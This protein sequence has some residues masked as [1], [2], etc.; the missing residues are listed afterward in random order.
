MTRD[1][2]ASYSFFLVFHQNFLQCDLLPSLSVLCFKHLSVENMRGQQTNVVTLRWGL[3]LG[4]SP[5]ALFRFRRGAMGATQL[6]LATLTHSNTITDKT[7]T[8]ESVRTLYV[9]VHTQMC[10]VQFWPFF[11]IWRTRHR[12]EIQL[13]RSISTLWRPPGR[14]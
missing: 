1:R 14:A 9:K 4:P 5:W 8:V 10:L 12:R 11:H 13:H 3:G 7:D 6:V 2:T